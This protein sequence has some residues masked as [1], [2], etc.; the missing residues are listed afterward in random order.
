MAKP[1]VAER[2]RFLAQSLWRGRCWRRTAT[3]KIGGP[4]SLAFWKIDTIV[5]AGLHHPLIALMGNSGVLV[6]YTQI[7]RPDGV[8]RTISSKPLRTD[9]GWRA[10]DRPMP[11]ALRRQFRPC[12]TCTWRASLNLSAIRRS[13]WMGAFRPILK[14]AT[15]EMTP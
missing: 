10:I 2:M 3:K 4:L 8:S 15:P 11:P 6:F 12:T 13:G 9:G 7:P 1:D 5:R 14:I